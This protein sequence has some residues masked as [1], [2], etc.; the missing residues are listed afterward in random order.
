MGFTETVALGA[1]AG[2]TIYIGLPLGRMRGVDDRM[3]VCL[4]MF[5][6]GILAFIFMDV[7]K[8][9]E[10]ILEAAVDRLRHDTGSFGHVA[11]LVRL[12]VVG[13]VIGTADI[14]AVE[15]KLRSRRAGPP[16][17]AGGEAS[18]VLAADQLARAQEGA[19]DTRRR[20]AHSVRVE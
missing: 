7:T 11:G 3:R 16:P 17:V 10:A 4:A 8:H 20:A 19:E 1:I 2:L 13:F 6:V 5:S 9:G 12:L 15:R 14:P 18:A